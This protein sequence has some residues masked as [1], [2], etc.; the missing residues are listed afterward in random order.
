MITYQQYVERA[1]LKQNTFFA[2]GYVSATAAQYG[3]VELWNPAT[4]GLNIFVYRVFMSA[5]AATLVTIRSHT[6]KLG[7][8]AAT[9]SNFT[10]GSGHEHVAE[11]YQFANAAPQGTQIGVMFI[12]AGAAHNHLTD[13]LIVPPGRSIILASGTVNADF[14]AGM[15]WAEVTLAPP[16]FS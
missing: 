13:G 14:Y 3:H 4:S 15:E 2:Y 5:A 9:H 10:L 8:V 11:P 7:S 1:R 16:N 12:A 6:S